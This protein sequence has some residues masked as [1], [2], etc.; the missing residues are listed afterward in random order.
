MKLDKR[1]KIVEVE[2]ADAQSSLDAMPISELEK[3]EPALTKSCGYLMKKDKKK[4]V[5]AF[6]IFGTNFE[7]EVL[8]KHYQIIPMKMIKKIKALK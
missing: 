5:L 6:M 4:I 7:G 8:M 3:Q 2:W 1:V